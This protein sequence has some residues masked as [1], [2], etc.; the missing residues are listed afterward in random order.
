MSNRRPTQPKE[1]TFYESTGQGLADILGSAT[2]DEPEP[3]QHAAQ[4]VE[5]NVAAG[6]L[7]PLGGLPTLPGA[8]G[9]DGGRLDPGGAP[10][11]SARESA[12]SMLTLA[13]AMVP[14]GDWQPE[15]DAER[16]EL[17]TALQRVFEYRGFCPSLPPELALIAITGKYARKR[18]ARPHVA[19]KAGPFLAR[20]P[21]IG[22]LLG[23]P[24]PQPVQP[25]APAQQSSSPFASLAPMSPPHDIR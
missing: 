11:P 15:T 9:I 4:I 22:K 17:I 12:E 3:A 19:A 1:T 25:T 18:M 7:D 14:T 16:D 20:L 8:T 24:A 23:A 2:A 6:A 5:T 13:F 21:L 10:P